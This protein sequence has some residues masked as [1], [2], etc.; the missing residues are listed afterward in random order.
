LS[1]VPFI[2]AA[3]AAES[4]SLTPGLINGPASQGVCA[5]RPASL[6]DFPR[7]NETRTSAQS[8]LLRVI[9]AGQLPVGV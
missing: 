1:M 8:I 5:A 7:K 4:S 9:L 3:L 6:S 2:G